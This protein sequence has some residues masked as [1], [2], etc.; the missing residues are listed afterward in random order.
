MLEVTDATFE[1]EVLQAT[2]PTLVDF[3]ATWCAPCRM[4]APIVEEIA[5]EQSGRMKVAKLDVDS[6]MSTAVR[7]GVTS[8]PTLILFKEGKEVKRLIGYRPKETLMA[9]LEPL[10]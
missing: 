7:Y 3:W 6:N 9:D 4:V 2:L 1:S 5:Q 10:L 8:I